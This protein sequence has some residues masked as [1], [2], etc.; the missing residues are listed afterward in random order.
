MKIYNYLRCRNKTYAEMNT[1]QLLL[2]LFCSNRQEIYQTQNEI[3]RAIEVNFS[4]TRTQGAISK[5][6]KKIENVEIH[7]NGEVFIIQKID[8]RYRLYTREA[9]LDEQMRKLAEAAVFKVYTAY[10]VTKKVIAYTIHEKQ[11]L[12]TENCMRLAFGENAFFDIVSHGDKLYFL[13]NDGTD[14]YSELMHFPKRVE[15]VVQEYTNAAQKKKP[16][17]RS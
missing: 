5:A 12:Y 10:F 6:L 16:V 9:V 13:L 3:V 17:K 11:H 1:T 14:F 8:D 4:V 2:E 7:Y 15:K